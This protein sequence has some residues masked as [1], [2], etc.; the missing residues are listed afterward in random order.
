[1]FAL[2][3]RPNGPAS[4]TAL[5]A[6]ANPAATPGHPPHA[7]EIRQHLAR[8]VASAVFRDSLRL[9]HFLTFVVE[10]TLAGSADR[11]KS[12]T[13]AIEALGRGSDFDPQADPIVRVEAGRL[14]RA[15]AHYYATAGRDDALLIELPLGNY[16]P[17]FR[18]RHAEASDRMSSDPLSGD[19]TNPSADIADRTRQLG[20][21]LA[22]VMELAELQ[23]R[24]V[25]T[26]ADVIRSARQ[27]LGQSHAAPP[28]ADDP[29]IACRPASWLLP[30]A[31]SS[32]TDATENGGWPTSP[33]NPTGSR[34]ACRAASPIARP[35]KSR[36]PA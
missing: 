20:R 34:R 36:R 11:I 22:A 35:A 18:R 28:G 5:A 29:A 25:A 16:V 1:M 23:R 8:V 10:T 24:Q 3:Q 15:L 13:I 32:R 14:R 4:G 2:K 33:T 12:Y 30:T 31:P 19:S 17:I 6:A 9:K 7:T 21:L 27:T 26:I